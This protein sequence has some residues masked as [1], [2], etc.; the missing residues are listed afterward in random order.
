MARTFCS[1]GG[2]ARQRAID[3]PDF[4]TSYLSDEMCAKLIILS[5]LDE[6]PKPHETVV[7]S[8][9]K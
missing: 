6:T 5:V 8:P 9:R 1:A 2:K 3:R 7:E 4:H